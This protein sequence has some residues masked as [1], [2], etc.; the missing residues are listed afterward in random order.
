MADERKS[1]AE[2]GSDEHLFISR[3]LEVDARNGTMTIAWSESRE[4]NARITEKPSIAFN[5][6][7][8]GLHFQFIADGPRVTDAGNRSAVPLRC[9]SFSRRSKRR[10]AGREPG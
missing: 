3:L 1:S 7:H 5:A 4:A 8:A 6:N 9:G 2:L 10:P